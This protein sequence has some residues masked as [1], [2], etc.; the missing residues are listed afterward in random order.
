MAYMSLL[1]DMSCIGSNEKEELH[2][3]IP[4]EQTFNS[5]KLTT[6]T[7]NTLVWCARPIFII[8]RNTKILVRRDEQ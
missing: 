1:C 3:N 7:N 6:Q 4:F 5:N 2:H 8:V